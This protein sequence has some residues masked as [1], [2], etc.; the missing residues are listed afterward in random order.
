MFL[1][2]RVLMFLLLLSNLAYGQS[3]GGFTPGQILGA[4]QL[5]SAFALKQDFPVPASA[6]S[7]VFSTTNTWVA[8]QAFVGG[9][10]VPTLTCAD[11]STSAASTAFALACGGGVSSSVASPAALAAT[12]IPAPQTNITVL[13]M[14]ASGT[15]TCS[16]TFSKGT[17]A[18]TGIYGEVLN[19]ASGIYW[20]PRYSNSPVRACEF[21]TVADGTFNNVTGAVTG[22]DNTTAIQASIDYALQNKYEAVCLSDGKYKTT[23]TIQLGWGNTFYS[24]SLTSCN[25]GRS[26]YQSSTA[27]VGIIP[28]ATDR[29]AINFQGGRFDGIKGMAIT[30]QNVPFFFFGPIPTP[31]PST[32]SG[33]ISSTLAAMAPGGLS[34]YSPYAGVCIDAYSG[35]PPITVGGTPYPFI[36]PPAWTGLSSTSVSIAN[37][38]PAVITWPGSSFSAGNAVIF[39][40]G[41]LPA[42][43]SLNTYYYVKTPSGA[44]FSLAA[45]PGGTSIDS[46]GTGSNLTT[47]RQYGMLATSDTLIENMDIGGFAVNINIESSNADANADFTKLRN[48]NLAN[49]AYGFSVGHDQSRNVDF[50]GTVNCTFG[51]ACITNNQ[52][53]KRTGKLGGPISNISGGES[54]QLFEIGNLSFGQPTTINDCYAEGLVRIGTF[55]GGSVPNSV[56]INGCDISAEPAGTSRLVPI[57]YLEAPSGKVAFTLNDINIGGGNRISKLIHGTASAVINGGSYTEGTV[58]IP[59]L[60]LPGLPVAY[61][62]TGGM[63]ISGTT[64]S[65]PAT[66]G[67]SAW[68]LNPQTT[69]YMTSQTAFGSGALIGRQVDFGTYGNRAP[70]TQATRG[71]YDGLNKRWNEFATAPPTANV[72]LS[73]GSY[74]GT[75]AAI[76]SCDVLTFTYLAAFQAANS[77]SANINT[78]DILDWTGDG[79]FF[80][81]TQVGALSGGAYPITARQMNNMAINADT[82]CATNNINDSTLTGIT[83]IIHTAGTLFSDVSPIGAGTPGNIMIPQFLYFGDFANGSTSIQNI[84]LTGPA[85]A[86]TTLT[87][88]NVVGDIIWQYPFNDPGQ[89]WPVAIGTKLS[90]VTN[91]TPGTITLSSAANLSGRFPISPLPIVGLGIQTNGISRLPAASASGG[92]CAVNATPTAGNQVRGTIALTGV[93]VAT[94]TIT[95]TFAINGTTGWDCSLKDRTAAAILIPQTSS[96]VTSAT[97]TVQGTTGATD[98]LGYG[99]CAP[100]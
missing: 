40:A 2:A 72:N 16:L 65:F 15:S 14:V 48:V 46:A 66:N 67:F 68:W 13:A 71:F 79:T 94:N 12:V 60:N 74:T 92:T 6:F 5:N 76:S 9:L 75:P 83:T 57:A 97:F 26:S 38:T 20:E 44:T 85:G 64:L 81:V 87:T 77:Q 95:L 50:S 34:R 39:T 80:V 8:L 17:S 19:A 91:G 28:T 47:S 4:T 41:S 7:S 36:N 86:A 49:H 30:G 78:G 31:W 58:G 69:E 59:F 82:S 23:D 56:T 53:G 22:T 73:S 27:G 18:P 61:N 37:G 99:E 63:M 45:T 10:T 54:Y 21:S 55:S 11:N 42:G 89:S 51:F 33:W 62:Y 88:Y 24:I 93:C 100:Y 43:F 52:F 98:V 25:N 96:T 32:A 84:G 3:S 70:F 1:A 29:C 90:T 35:D